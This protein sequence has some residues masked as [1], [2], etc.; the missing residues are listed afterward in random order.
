LGC[1]SSLKRRGSANQQIAELRLVPK[2]VFF[3]LC[4]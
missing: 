2:E 4:R 3:K 1:D